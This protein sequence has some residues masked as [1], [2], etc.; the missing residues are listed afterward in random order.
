[1]RTQMHVSLG[2][3]L[4]VLIA[5]AGTTGTAHARFGHGGGSHG[6]GSRGGGG[7]HGGGFHSS[8]GGGVRSY[9]GGGSR[10]YG[11][12]SFGRSRETVYVRGRPGFR[13]STTVSAG[14]SLWA[15]PRFSAGWAP[16]RYYVWGYGY[17]VAPTLVVRPPTR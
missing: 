17:A 3:V 14:P 2:V 15:A 5:V 1:M 4:S 12:S 6:G 11:G 7:W 13:S 8:G 9:G 10:S 16:S